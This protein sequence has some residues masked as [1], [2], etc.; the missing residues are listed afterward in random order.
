MAARIF[1]VFGPEGSTTRATCRLLMRAGCKGDDGWVQPFDSNP[2]KAALA[3]LAVWRKTAS[4]RRCP[5]S[6]G[7]S[8]LPRR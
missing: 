8:C 2:P 5:T 3:P 4:S 6:R 1:L 7:T